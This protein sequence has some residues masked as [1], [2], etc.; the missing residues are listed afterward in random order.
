MRPLFL[1]S[2]TWWFWRLL[3]VEVTAIKLCENLGRL[4]RGLY[5]DAYTVALEG[6][7]SHMWGCS[8]TLLKRVWRLLRKLPCLLLNWTRRMFVF[9]ACRPTLTLSSFFFE[10]AGSWAR[11]IHSVFR[12]SISE[13]GD[14]VE[15]TVC[16]RHEDICA[17]TLKGLDYAWSLPEFGTNDN[18]AVGGSSGTS[19]DGGGSSGATRLEMAPYCSF[20]IQFPW[21]VFCTSLLTT[22]RLMPFDTSVDYCNDVMIVASQVLFPPS[23]Q[24]L[25]MECVVM[26]PIG[27]TVPSAAV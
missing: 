8:T 18:S 14:V 5:T 9:C 1:S 7:D 16:V 10:E 17:G 25:Q 2:R 19:G 4:H 3:P 27:S 11:Q 22:L 24:Y 26:L 23:S 15:T 6:G 12:A 13:H 21:L 20:P